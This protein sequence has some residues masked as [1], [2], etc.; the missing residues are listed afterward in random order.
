MRRRMSISRALAA[1][2]FVLSTGLAAA[3]T[4][5]AAR[6]GAVATNSSSKPP[7]LLPIPDKLVVLTFDDAKASHY[8]VVRP[9]LKRY[10][11][12]A[13]FFISEGFSF[14]SNKTDYLTW[15]QIARL[16]QDG[17]EI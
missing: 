14:P 11:F 1:A 6:A 7:G 10:G 2:L 17:F 12:G 9:L 4:S 8:T 16:H 15:E 13:T 3:Q 5:A